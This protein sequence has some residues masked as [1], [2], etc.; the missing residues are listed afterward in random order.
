MSGT[1]SLIGQTFSH[2]CILEKLR[3]MRA[4]YVSIDGQGNV[5]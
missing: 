2:Y 1:D 5:K 3:G 4:V